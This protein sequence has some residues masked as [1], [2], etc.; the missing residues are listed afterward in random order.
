MFLILEG[1][2]DGGFVMTPKVRLPSMSVSRA[3]RRTTWF[4][5]VQSD[6]KTA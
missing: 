4:G 6:L 2:R 5:A 3:R 1:W